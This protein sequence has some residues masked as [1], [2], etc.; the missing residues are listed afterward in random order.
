MNKYIEGYTSDDID[1]CPF[2]PSDK[3]TYQ[4]V[5]GKYKCDECGKAFYV[6]EA[7]E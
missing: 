7:E 4:P 1:N 6:I 3:I 2:C 5:I